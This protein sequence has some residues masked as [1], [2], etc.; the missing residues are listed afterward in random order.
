M[1]RA[2]VDSGR[3]I[4]RRGKTVASWIVLVAGVAAGLGVA[5][6]NSGDSEPI[7]LPAEGGSWALASEMRADPVPSQLGK[8]EI[9]GVGTFTY[10]PATLKTVRPDVFAEGRF[11]A[12]DALAALAT[13]GSVDVQ[14]AYDESLA[15]YVIRS[16]NGLT[17]WWY[18]VRLPGGAFERTALRMDMY[19]L[20]D[21]AEVYLYLEDPARL[22]AIESSFREEVAL[23]EAHGGRTIIPGVTIKGPR[24]TVTFRD[25]VATSHNVRPDVFRPGAITALDVLLSLG[26]Q[27]L[28]AGLELAWHAMVDDVPSVNHYMVD[29]ISLPDVLGERNSS[30]GYMD[31]AATEGLRGFLTPH[32]HATTRIHLSSDL[33]L[34]VSPEYVEWQWLCATS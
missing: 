17:G 32:S 11:S 7:L 12:F 16:I 15:T 25:V 20:K 6:G 8:L 31:E 3:W 9:R 1:R 5:L 34:L 22:A 18:D 27:G 28:I 13:A 14:Y 30:C 4:M 26:D 21:G 2:D 33:E 29:W 23:R 24:S 19:P 10:D